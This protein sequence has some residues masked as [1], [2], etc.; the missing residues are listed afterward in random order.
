ARGVDSSRVARRS[1]K[2]KEASEA[3]RSWA[4]NQRALAR[5]LGLTIEDWLIAID[6]AAQRTTGLTA[7]VIGAAMARGLG[8]SVLAGLDGAKLGA[9]ARELIDPRPPRVTSPLLKEAIRRAD[10][11]GVRPGAGASR[12]KRASP[13]TRA[14][15]PTPVRE[16]K[17][18]GESAKEG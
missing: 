7:A 11:L 12:L 9:G 2:S 16:T 3:L 1:A 8:R 17:P 4:D 6:G 14:E 13:R 5:A 18:I 15:I 10:D